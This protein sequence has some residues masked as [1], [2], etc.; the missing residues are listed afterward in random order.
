MGSLLDAGYLDDKGQ[1]TP[2]AEER[3]S[4]RTGPRG[5]ELLLTPQNC[6]QIVFNQEDVRQLQ[7]AKSAVRTAA[8]ILMEKAG[9][10]NKK[11]DAVFLAGTFGS[12]VDPKQAVRIGLLP[13]VKTGIIRNIGNAAAGGAMK[14]LLSPAN[15]EEARKMAQRV[16]YA[17]LAGHQEFSDLFIRI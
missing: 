5:A 14:A 2:L 16:K 10:H 15:Q 3:L 11:L 9:I 6:P 7:L 8:D 1:F 17:E 13:P 4:M 12:Y